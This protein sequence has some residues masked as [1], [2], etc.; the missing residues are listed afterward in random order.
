MWYAKGSYKHV[1][2]NFLKYRI[3]TTKGQS[4]SP[5]IKRDKGREFIIGV[6]IGSN[7]K[8]T[9]NLAVRLTPQKR[10]TINEWV[11]DVTGALNLDK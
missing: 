8:S 1:T 2:E 4:G 11:G 7:D 10:K 3:P 6:H 5:V 9:R